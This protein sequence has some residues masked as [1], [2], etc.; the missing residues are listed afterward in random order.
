MKMNL[1]GKMGSVLWKRFGRGEWE[2]ALWS[3]TPS[4]EKGPSEHQAQT[5]IFDGCSGHLLWSYITSRGHN[6]W[7]G[8]FKCSGPGNSVSLTPFH[9]SCFHAQDYP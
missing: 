3:H 7:L 5:W 1:L 9:L 6:S 4:L 2:R 8:R